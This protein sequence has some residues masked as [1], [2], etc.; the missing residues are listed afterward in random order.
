MEKGIFEGKGREG[1]GIGSRMRHVS[2]L[3]LFNNILLSLLI[4][5]GA[6]AVKALKR[7]PH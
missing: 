3:A 5:A 6:V 1:G 2:L 7:Q 4:A